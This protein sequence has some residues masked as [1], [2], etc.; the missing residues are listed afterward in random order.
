MV[1]TAVRE[2]RFWL[3]PNAQ[4]FHPIFE[5]ELADLEAER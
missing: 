1:V 3:L 2:K 5:R 4:V